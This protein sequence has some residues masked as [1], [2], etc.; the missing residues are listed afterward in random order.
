MAFRTAG[1]HAHGAPAQLPPALCY[2]AALRGPPVLLAGTAPAVARHQEPWHLVPLCTLS[3][4]RLEESSPHLPEPPVP[5]QSS[6]GV[7]CCK[8]CVPAGLRS[9]V[10]SAPLGNMG[11]HLRFH[12]PKGVWS[13][14][15]LDR[16]KAESPPPSPPKKMSTLGPYRPS[17]VDS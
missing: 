8:Y 13:V 4:P 1:G 6:V 2:Q 11:R 3:P 12:F 14:Q 10:S 16:K 17:T 7:S 5:H 9:I 15:K